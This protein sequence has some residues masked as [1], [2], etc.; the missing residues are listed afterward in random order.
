MLSFLDLTSCYNVL[1]I[2]LGIFAQSIT[3]ARS[4]EVAQGFLYVKHFVCLSMVPPV[5]GLGHP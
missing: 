3:W 5:E 1:G 4:F 2:S